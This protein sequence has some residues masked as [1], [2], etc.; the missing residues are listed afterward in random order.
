[1]DHE[2]WDLASPVEVMATCYNLKERQYPFNQQ[3]VVSSAVNVFDLSTCGISVGNLAT[4]PVEYKQCVDSPAAGSAGYK[5]CDDSP[6]AGSGGY[7]Q[8]VDNPVAVP[9]K[10][11]QCVDS[12]AMCKQQGSTR[13]G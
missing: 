10:Y 12:H 3:P 8:C 7:K 2:F 13:G 4:G 5:Q 6:V 9:D 1:M 11:K